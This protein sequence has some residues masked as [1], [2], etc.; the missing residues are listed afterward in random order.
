[1][2]WCAIQAWALDEADRQRVLGALA[3]FADPNDI[4]PDNV[5]VLGFL[6]DAVMIR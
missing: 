2:Q 6:D 3:Y 5:A 1:M 4:I